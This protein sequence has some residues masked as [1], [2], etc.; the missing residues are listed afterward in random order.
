MIRAPHT[1]LLV[2]RNFTIV[3]GEILAKKY[4]HVKIKLQVEKRLCSLDEEVEEN[5]DR[6]ILCAR[7]LQS[8]DNPSHGVTYWFLCLGNTDERSQTAAV[9]SEFY[10]FWRTLF[11]GFI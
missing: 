2:V 4:K 8:L 9:M 7:V 11:L 3:I 6:D 1:L 10:Q 5:L